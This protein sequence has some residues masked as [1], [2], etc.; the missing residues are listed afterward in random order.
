MDSRHFYYLISLLYRLN[1][2]LFIDDLTFCLFFF[3]CIMST[4]VMVRYVL[5][6]T[7]YSSLLL[8]FNICLAKLAKFPPSPLLAGDN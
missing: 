5:R 1:H 2:E 7:P 8:V 3:P 4:I 6:I